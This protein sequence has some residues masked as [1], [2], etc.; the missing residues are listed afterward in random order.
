N[1]AEEHTPVVLTIWESGVPQMTTMINMPSNN[2]VPD[3]VL[4]S[5]FTLYMNFCCLG[6]RAF[7][8]SVKSRDR[9]MLGHLTRAQ[10]FASTAKCQ[11]IWAL[12]FNIILTI[13][14]IVIFIFSAVIF[15]VISLMI[16]NHEGF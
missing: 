3:H 13:G 10:A 6:F 5:L 15:Q 8:Y 2:S 14:F 12:I 16:K 1:S 7:T 4:W 11:N 9:K